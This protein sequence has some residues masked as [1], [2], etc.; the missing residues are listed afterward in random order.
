[1]FFLFFVCFVNVFVVSLASSGL[2]QSTQGTRCFKVYF[3]CFD[4]SAVGV[5]NG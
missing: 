5:I 4:V 2:P 3:A 1:V